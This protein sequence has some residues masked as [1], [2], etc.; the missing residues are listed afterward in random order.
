MENGRSNYI[1][2]GDLGKPYS[3]IMQEYQ[4][5]S[6]DLFD[7]IGLI[8]S[9]CFPIVLLHIKYHQLGA[10][11]PQIFNKSLSYFRF[12]ACKIPQVKCFPSN[13]STSYHF[14][15]KSKAILKKPVTFQLH[16]N[17]ISTKVQKT[18]LYARISSLALNFVHPDSP[19]FSF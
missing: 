15:F 1:I 8:K 17:F 9:E 19:N 13:K 5:L 18:F 4:T 2:L 7:K 12:S 3:A 6:H 11:L 16:N 10:V 14:Q